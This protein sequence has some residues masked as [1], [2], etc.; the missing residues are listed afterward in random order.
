MK[1]KKIAVILLTLSST[2]FFV[3]LGIRTA[4]ADQ[5]NKRPDSIVTYQSAGGA[6]LVQA[7]TTPASITLDEC[8][9]RPDP[10]DNCSPCIRS[11]ETQ[12]CRLVDVVVTN[13]EPDAEGMAFISS[14]STFL[15]SCEKP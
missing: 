5:R 6:Y 8:S 11:L 10:I 15:L 1:I 4:M 14:R 7:R 9:V 13:F 3:S 12:G 2:V